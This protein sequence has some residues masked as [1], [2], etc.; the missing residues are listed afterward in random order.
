MGKSELGKLKDSILA[1]GDPN[2][3]TNTAKSNDSG[4][5]VSSDD[6]KAYMS[7]M[8]NTIWKDLYTPKFDP[9]S[10]VFNNP[11]S[12]SGGGNGGRSDW[13][14]TTFFD[15][16][17]GDEIVLSPQFCG[18]NPDG[19]GRWRTNEY[20]VVDSAGTPVFD[21]QFGQVIGVVSHIDYNYSNS[22]LAPETRVTI[23]WLTTNESSVFA[24]TGDRSRYSYLKYYSLVLSKLF[25]QSPT[26]AKD[27]KITFKINDKFFP[28]SNAVVGFG[29][30][31]EEPKEK[32]KP[33]GV[34]F[35]DVILSKKKKDQVLEA[36]EQVNNYDLIFNEWGFGDKIEKGRAVSM[37]FY[38][39]PGTG[40]TLISQAIANKLNYKLQIISTAE[41][42]SQEPGGAERALKSFFKAAEDDKKTVLLFDECD[43][44]VSSREGVGVILG[45]QINALLTELEKYTGI[46]IFATNRLGVLDSA[47][48]RRLSLKLE[49]TLPTPKQRLKIW[50]NMFPE[51][52]PLA[53]DIRWEGLAQAEIAGGHVKNVVLKAARRA[54]AGDKLITD[55]ILWDALEEE[56]KS[57]TDFHEA[58]DNHLPRAI[59]GYTRNAIGQNQLGKGGL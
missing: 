35:D 46:A 57:M 3:S 43:S 49:F 39:L 34:S 8:S 15:L 16:A 53:D 37:L 55:D 32:P 50:K 27:P 1:M 19:L 58:A 5:T 13:H 31:R 18:F 29:L 11:S 44:L 10:H 17:V 2:Y 9:Y 6:M 54:A 38:G 30:G 7:I 42:E 36:I 52:A 28:I 45:A 21:G 47:F 25:S 20:V 33:K 56:V 41:I 12:P 22:S 48:E 14:D 26:S 59:G 51:K 40:K 23:S 4:S 24:V